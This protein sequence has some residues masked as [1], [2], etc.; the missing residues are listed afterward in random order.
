MYYL[1]GFVITLFFLTLN[2]PG[3]VNAQNGQPE[4]ARKEIQQRRFTPYQPNSAVFQSNEHDNNA[5]E[6]NFSFRYLI[7]P[8][9]CLDKGTGL[10]NGHEHKWEHFVTYT[11]K[12]DFYMGTRPSSPVINRLNNPAWHSRV[13]FSDNAMH[14]EWLDIGV[15]HK[16]NGQTTSADVINTNTGNNA[17]EEAYLAGNR[18]YIDSISR[19]TNYISLE[20]KFHF[21]MG[22]FSNNKLYVKL[23]A[24]HWNEESDVHWGRYANQNINFSD[25]ERI[26]TILNVQL[27]DT[28]VY[29]DMVELGLEW[30]VGDKGMATDSANV[31]LRWP[32]DVKLPL[33]GQTHFPLILRAHIGPM[34]ELSN[35]SESE[36]SIGIGLAFFH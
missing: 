6:V 20:A 36:R 18:S 14:A 7:S 17:A 34:N 33:F 30:T 13:Y 2:V 26:R 15:E 31:W 4:T 16:S 28:N 9:K 3:I 11:G 22:S 35:Y 10:C 25:F 24:H 12:F 27:N 23:F 32:W 19:S 8:P 5:I 29:D 21:D 1:K